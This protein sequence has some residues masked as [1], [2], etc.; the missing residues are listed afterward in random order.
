MTSDA[1]VARQ[2]ADAAAA[3]LE[4]LDQWQFA[5]ASWSFADEA[6]RCRWYYTPTDHG[7]LP[8][9]AMQPAQ[10][11]RAHQLL[12]SGLSTPGYYTACAIMGLEN[13]LDHVEGWTA[14]YHRHRGR[15]PGLYFFRVFGDPKGDKPWSWRVGGHHLSINYTIADGEVVGATPLFLGADPASVALLGPSEHRPLASAEDL[16]KQLVRSLDDEQ[17]SAALLTPVAPTDV[18]G[19]NRSEVA[20]GTGDLP[21]PLIDVWRSPF[22]G[23][24]GDFIRSVQA[25]ADIEAGI[26]AADLEALRLEAEPKGVSARTFR[27]EQRALLAALLDSYLGRAPSEV[28]AAARL[29]HTAPGVLEDLS[30]AWAGGT[31]DHDGH[32]YRVQGHSLLIEYGNTQRHAN[33]IHSVWRD[34]LNDFGRDE[35]RRRGHQPPGAAST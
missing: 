20:T 29:R 7:G 3:L 13:I 11:R 35:L 16:A 32:Y 23:E 24:L 10:Q 21:L 1:P 19:A 2:M 28:A 18:V 17:R 9:S 25:R 33:H 26:T 34:L 15:D 8:L 12:A 6:E 4:S 27:P 22:T 31:G 30:F 5:Q 14:A